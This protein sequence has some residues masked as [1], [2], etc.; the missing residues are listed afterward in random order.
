MILITSLGPSF[1]FSQGKFILMISQP[2]S[3]NSEPDEKVGS[4]LPELVPNNSLIM[5]ASSVL[6]SVFGVDADVREMP[7]LGLSSETTFGTDFELCEFKNV[8]SEDC[9][10]LYDCTIVSDRFLLTDPDDDFSCKWLSNFCVDCLG[11]LL[12][13]SDGSGFGSSFKAAS[14]TILEVDL[15]PPLESDFELK[16]LNELLLFTLSVN[17]SELNKV[18]SVPPEL[19]SNISLIMDDCCSS[20]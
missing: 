19:A 6:S 18:E 3:E 7:L 5:H 10:L 9:G 13:A 16:L 8:S 20:A 1:L 2:S 14:F 17:I 11:S 12:I 4:V 15:C